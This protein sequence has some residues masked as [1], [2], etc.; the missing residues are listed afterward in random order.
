MQEIITVLSSDVSILSSIPISR[1]PPSYLDTISAEAQDVHLLISEPDSGM[2][3]GYISKSTTLQDILIQSLNGAGVDNITKILKELQKNKSDKRHIELGG[4]SGRA[5]TYSINVDNPVLTSITET[6]NGNICAVAGYTLSS[7]MDKV[8][9]KTT[10]DIIKTLSIDSPVIMSGTTKNNKLVNEKYVKDYA[11]VLSGYSN[12]LSTYINQVNNKVIKNTTNIYEISAKLSALSDEVDKTGGLTTI[13]SSDLSTLIKKYDTDHHGQNGDVMYT[14]PSGPVK[15]SILDS[16]IYICETDEEIEESINTNLG[17]KDIWNNWYKGGKYS[18]TNKYWYGFTD[19][20]TQPY[21]SYRTTGGSWKITNVQRNMVPNLTA[22]WNSTSETWNGSSRNTNTTDV[23]CV[24]QISCGSETQDAYMYYYIS[25]DITVQTETYRYRGRISFNTFVNNITDNY[26]KQL[27]LTSTNNTLTCTLSFD[28]IGSTSIPLEKVGGF[29]YNFWYY[30]EDEDT[31]VQ[32]D[33]TVDN[34]FIYSPQR[35]ENYEL[36]IRL[37]STNS[38]DDEIGIILAFLPSVEDS[39]QKQHSGKPRFLAAVRSPNNTNDSEQQNSHWY[40]VD[41][42]INVAS[43]YKD[44]RININNPTNEAYG[45]W[46]NLNG[47]TIITA[48]RTGSTIEVKTT[49]FQQN[50]TA[51]AVK[52]MTPTNT[53]TIDLTKVCNGIFNKPASIGYVSV[54]QPDSMYENIKFDVEKI[55]V[56]TRN[57]SLSVYNPHTKNCIQKSQGVQTLAQCGYGRFIKNP[58]SQKTFYVTQNGFTRVV[59]NPQ[60]ETIPLTFSV[61]K[62][63][64]TTEDFTYNVVLNGTSTPTIES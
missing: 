47:G 22:S 7:G 62:S 32:P 16:N 10:F 51:D 11:N 18:Y 61:I 55:I 3:T 63:N 39:T 58:L 1:L 35:Y 52:Q 19:Y 9:K 56:D 38:D 54:S 37:Y 13:I 29:G 36:K 45:G 60:Y 59:H 31:I 26:T 43:N 41:S 23:N 33:N 50:A 14:T 40:I 21:Q 8:F 48:K 4:V 49:P 20:P 53:M 34:T 27:Q 17:F 46:S 64:G 6:D 15:Q 57:N 42:Y 30:K 24:T 25:V 44:Q 5:G 28:P 12:R 2:D